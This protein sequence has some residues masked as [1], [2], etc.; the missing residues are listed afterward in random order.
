M[1]K[2]GCI[3]LGFLIGLGF[4]Y[5][6]HYAVVE[7]YITPQI[8]E[9]IKELKLNADD[10]SKIKKDL[11]LNDIRIRNLESKL[12]VK[13]PVQIISTSIKEKKGR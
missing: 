5:F 1:S 3:L 13:K 7:N 11:T 6:W 10:F 8:N 4:G 9:I 12:G 2:T